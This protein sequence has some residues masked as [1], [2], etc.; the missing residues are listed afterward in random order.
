MGQTRIGGIKG[1]RREDGMKRGEN[2]K[3]IPREERV[4]LGRQGGIVSGKVKLEKLLDG[5]MK[6]VREQGVYAALKVC[7]EESWMRGYDACK[8]QELR[9]EKSRRRS[10]STESQQQSSD[11][12]SRLR[13]HDGSQSTGNQ[14]VRESPASEQRTRRI[15]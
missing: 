8:K 14:T 4:R 3:A 1:S 10:T 6:I 13:G 15:A 11:A 12:R 7:R 2:L 5:Y 9:R